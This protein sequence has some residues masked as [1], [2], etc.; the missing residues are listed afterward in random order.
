MARVMQLGLVSVIEFENESITKAIYAISILFS[1]WNSSDKWVSNR[2]FDMLLTQ[3]VRDR[4]Y[5]IILFP[6][7]RSEARQWEAKRLLAQFLDAC[8][9]HVDNLRLSYYLLLWY[10]IEIYTRRENPYQNTFV[11]EWIDKKIGDVSLDKQSQQKW[12]VGWNG[13]VSVVNIAGSVAS[14]PSIF[15]MIA[16]LLSPVKR[17]IHFK[18]II[19]IIFV[20]IVSII[21]I[22]ILYKK[23]VEY[24]SSN[25]RVSDFVSNQV[26]L[27]SATPESNNFSES[28]YE[29]EQQLD[30]KFVIGQK[31]DARKLNSW[32]AVPLAIPIDPNQ[33]GEWGKRLSV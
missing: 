17:N 10:N 23:S 22:W 16:K 27:E 19:V 6:I 25:V 7:N 5:F 32:S 13:V 12:I 8:A 11:F 31:Y 15:K 3:L 1:T 9:A 20:I 21:P 24:H 33:P 2:L 28:E 4:I 18:G 14:T 26:P 29:D 30:W